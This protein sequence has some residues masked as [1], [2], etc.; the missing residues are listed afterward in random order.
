MGT[1][2]TMANPDAHGVFNG[3]VEPTL[4]SG[5]KYKIRAI[6]AYGGS[7][8]VGFIPFAAPVRATA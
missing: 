5:M 6:I 8:Y 3:Y 1:D 2:Q 7:D 4:E